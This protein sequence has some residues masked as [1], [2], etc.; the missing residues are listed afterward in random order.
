MEKSLDVRI[1]ELPPAQVAAAVALG[2]AP[3]ARAIQKLCAWAEEHDLLGNH[4]G[5]VFGFNNPD[6][7]PGTSEYGYEVWMVV[8]PGVQP[9]DEVTLKTF[10][11]GLY[12]V[13]RCTGVENITSTWQALV[14]WLKSSPYQMG[15]HRWLEEH[16]DFPADAG[17][18][19]HLDLCL[20]VK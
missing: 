14:D 5:R 13:T 7:A 3:E 9:G 20:P 19:F 16:L 10:S 11:G 2:P 18:D 4:Q 1:I 17:D 8:A 6:P 12:A 15:G